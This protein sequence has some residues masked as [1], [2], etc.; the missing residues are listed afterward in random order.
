MYRHVCGKGAEHRR[1]FCVRLP[2]DDDRCAAIVERMKERAVAADAS[3]G[4]IA[5]K[6]RHRRA[7]IERR[8]ERHR[9]SRRFDAEACGGINERGAN[10]AGYVL[11]G[12]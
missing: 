4:G 8:A 7:E 9:Q 6:D 10:L 3:R 5:N 11:Q 1:R 12:R 2:R